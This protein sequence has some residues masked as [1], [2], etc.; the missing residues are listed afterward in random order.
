MYI[1]TRKQLEQFIDRARVSEV[2]AVDTEFLREKT[3]WPKLCLIQMGTEKESV[4][5]DPF[6]F[7]N[8]EPLKELFT[9]KKIVKLFHAASQDLEIIHSRARRA[10]PSRFS[11]RKSLRRCSAARC[12]LA[13]ERSL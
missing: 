2:L 4:A 12:R 10:S 8:L 13:T 5:I 7:D 1:T 3:Y 11:T 9:N 6:A